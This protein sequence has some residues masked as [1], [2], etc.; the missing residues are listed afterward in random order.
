MRARGY[1]LRFREDRGY[2]EECQRGKGCVAHREKRDALER[3]RR[4][5]FTVTAIA[6]SDCSFCDGDEHSPKAAEDKPVTTV[7]HCLYP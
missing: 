1:N 3:E 2:S 5:A 7:I 6:V 4:P